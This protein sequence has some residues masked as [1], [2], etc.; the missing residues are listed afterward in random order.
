MGFFDDVLQ[1]LG[2]TTG[3]E[4]EE[5]QQEESEQEETEEQES[6]GFLQRLRDRFRGEE[7]QEDE[8]ES[9]E[10]VDIPRPGGP[11]EN[12]EGGPAVIPFTKKETGGYM[13]RERVYS[14]VALDDCKEI[15][16]CLLSGESVLINLE[17]VDPKDC[18]RVVDLLSGA[19]FAVQG[20]I[21]KVAHLS[22]LLAPR[23]VEIIERRQTTP[24]ARYR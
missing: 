3:A 22:Y 10:P 23:N 9:E 17:N 24:S 15:I 4:E 14:V 5:E 21:V 12:W 19:A 11:S 2:F 20:K 16:R 13:H 8:E 7:E 18:G 6:R 1:K